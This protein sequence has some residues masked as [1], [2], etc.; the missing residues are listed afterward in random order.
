VERLQPRRTYAAF[1]EKGQIVNPCLI[2]TRN[3][4]DLTKRCVDSV[5]TQDIP[6]DIF[7][8]DNGS[9]DGTREWLY[10]E[11]V[12]ISMFL[13]EKNEGVS[14]GWNLGLDYL[15]QDGFDD[16]TYRPNSDHCLVIGNDTV[17]APWTYSA[18]LSVDAPFVTGVDAGMG[19]LPDKPDIYPLSP[20]PDFSCF[21]IRREC[22][23]K[24]GPFDE[25]MMMYAQD[26]DYHVRAHQLGVTLWK[27]SIPYN[28]ERSSTLNR[29]S[30]EERL[31]I[32]MR[33]NLD[34]EVFR[35]KY[36]CIPGQPAYEELFK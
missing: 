28:H 5:R 29:A 12:D 32:H 1:V 15:F 24:V 16:G 9:T 14:K 20:H 10:D 33:A 21:L 3:N 22:W 7:V 4:L 27:A 35:T 36:G 25:D 6:V 26:C 30:A 23:E 18:L 2:L 8:V 11:Y 19:P 31:A 34:R 13:R 17:L